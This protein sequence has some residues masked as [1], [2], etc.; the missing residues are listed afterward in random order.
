MCFTT[1][2]GYHEKAVLV[3]QDIPWSFVYSPVSFV[4]SFSIRWFTSR[5]A[6]NLGCESQNPGFPGVSS[7]PQFLGLKPKPKLAFVRVRT[8]LHIWQ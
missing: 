4:Y 1:C 2:T 8:L 3:L 6:E 5:N 7:K